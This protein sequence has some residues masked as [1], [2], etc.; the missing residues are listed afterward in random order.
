MQKIFFH[1]FVVLILCR[2]GTKIFRG[3]KAQI[4]HILK[5]IALRIKIFSPIDSA[6]P[7]SYL[8]VIHYVAL[9]HLYFL[10][11]LAKP[12]YTYSMLGW[13]GP[14]MPDLYVI[15]CTHQN[16]VCQNQCTL[17]LHGIAITSQCPPTV[18]ISRFSYQGFGLLEKVLEVEFHWE[19]EA[20]MIRQWTSAN[21]PQ[22]RK[23]RFYQQ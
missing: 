20:W 9:T 2:G 4:S 7:V 17:Q 3:A 15:H 14:I 16:C 13:V 12:Y 11:Y 19:V 6:T 21:L 8:S 1:N 18:P 10:S 22:K 5:S 23:V